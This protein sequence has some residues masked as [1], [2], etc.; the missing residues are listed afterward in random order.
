MAGK[1]LSDEQ[2]A[3]MREA[4]SLFDTDG[5]GRIAPSELGVLM[6]SLGGNPTQAQLRDITAQEKLTAP[7]DF[8]RFLELMR[9]HLR[10]E[11]FDR[12]LRDAFRVLDKDASGTVSVADLRHV[13]TSIGEKLEPHEFDE[14][15]REVDVAADGTIRYDDFIRRIVAKQPPPPSPELN[16]SPDAMGRMHSRGKGISSSA[17]PY[18]RTPPSWVKTAV[19]DVDELITKAAKKGQMPS[20]IGVLLRDQHGLAPEIP[21]DLYFLIKKA[22][23]IRKHLERNRK[24]KDSKF[25]LILV[26]SR[27]HRLARYYKRTK[28]LPPTWK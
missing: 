8:K 24:D 1:E 6:R 5:D 17:L 19:A 22:V 15:I 21:E 4:F 26:E 13:L 3:S 25:R 18:K 9:A 16:P 20:Q 14:W 27:I 2:V 23:A 11:P 10:P 12:P 7:F 28:K